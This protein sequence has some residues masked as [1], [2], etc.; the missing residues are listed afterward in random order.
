MRCCDNGWSSLLGILGNDRCC[1]TFTFYKFN[2]TDNVLANIIFH[3]ISEV[4]DT[5]YTKIL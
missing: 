5:F 4:A 3:M 2:N 1:V